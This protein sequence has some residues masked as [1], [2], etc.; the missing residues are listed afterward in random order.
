MSS[1]YLKLKTWLSY[2]AFKII[3]LFKRNKLSNFLFLIKN[4]T[5]HQNDSKIKNKR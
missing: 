4:T 3:F 5:Q 2:T 1:K